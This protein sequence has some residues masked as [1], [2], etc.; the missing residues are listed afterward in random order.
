H[1]VSLG[2]AVGAGSTGSGGQRAALGRGRR[3]VEPGA[4]VA[5]R[6]PRVLVLARNYSN[7]AFL[8]LGLWTERLVAASRTVAEPTVVAP[9][10]Y[11][12]PFLPLS[13]VRRFRAVDRGST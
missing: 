4:Q 5:M 12:P 1:H 6:K 3:T 8:T 10:P 13:S 7:N 2:G 11:A 9:V